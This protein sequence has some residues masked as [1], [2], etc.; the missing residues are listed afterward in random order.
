MDRKL[1]FSI[2]TIAVVAL[3]IGGGTYAYFSDTESSEDNTITAGTL[4]LSVDDENPWTS[5]KLTV[6]N[7]I[8]GSSGSVTMTLENE[9]SADGLSL[10][11]DVTDI[12]DGPGTTPESEP[13]SD[14]G[15]LS[16]NTDIV[17]WE[18]TNYD[19]VIDEGEDEIYNNTLSATATNG[20]WEIG[21][22]A[23]GA[24]NYVGLYY[25]IDETV[26]NEIQGDNCSFN[27]V[28]VL[29]QY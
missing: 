7:A 1:L 5:T 25:E 15:E 16:Q 3:L 13:T 29:S 10:T 26:G 22:L 9:G 28:Y 20:P 12:A 17:L 18:D 11:L 2:M 24:T 8:P 14:N 21:P 27:I 23:A 19:G 6:T 4:D